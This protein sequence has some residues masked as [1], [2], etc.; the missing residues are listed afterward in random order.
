MLI[1]S[2][3]LY[4][5]TLLSAVISDCQFLLRQTFHRKL[6]QDQAAG[7]CGRNYLSIELEVATSKVYVL[8]SIQP[9]LHLR[10]IPLRCAVHFTSPCQLPCM[11]FIPHAISYSWE[12]P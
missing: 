6:E 9:V 11:Y 1:N 2:A 10:F 7:P 8:A 5:Y 3:S 12:R 4:A